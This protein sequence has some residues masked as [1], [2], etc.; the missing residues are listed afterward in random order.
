MEKEID[1]KIINEDG[2]KLVNPFC[3]PQPLDEI[4]LPHASRIKNANRLF[5]EI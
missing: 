2:I 4:Y 5:D 1:Y 3:L